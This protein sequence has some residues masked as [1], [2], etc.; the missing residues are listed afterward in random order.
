MVTFQEFRKLME[1]RRI[2]ADEL[3]YK[4]RGKIE[5]PRDFLNRV[6]QERYDSVVIPYR[7][8]L[9]FYHQEKPVMDRRFSGSRTREIVKEFGG[10]FAPPLG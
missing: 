4:F 6:W 3:V 5:D 8:V 10:V 1:K 9:K 7:S 2:T